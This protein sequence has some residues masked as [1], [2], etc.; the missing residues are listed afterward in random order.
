MLAVAGDAYLRAGIV[1]PL[2]LNAL[3]NWP[4]DRAGQDLAG[5]ESP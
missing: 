2:D 4:L 5:K 1:A 3:A